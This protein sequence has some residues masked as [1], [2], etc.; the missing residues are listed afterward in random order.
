MNE[1]INPLERPKKSD[2]EEAAYDAGL[3]S[4]VLPKEGTGAYESVKKTCENYSSVVAQEM[5]A[6][7]P[8]FLEISEKKRRALHAELCVKLFGT[9]WQD[10]TPQAR[11]TARRFAHYV[12]GRPSF[13][14]DFKN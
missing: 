1:Q 2:L 5:V 7:S 11:D 14:E 8:T 12:A 6:S 9:S 4:V 13:A 3:K 10:T